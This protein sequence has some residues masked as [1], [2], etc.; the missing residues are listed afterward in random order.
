M[1]SSLHSHGATGAQRIEPATLPLMQYM[2]AGKPMPVRE[3]RL[4]RVLADDRLG[5][6]LR[7]MYGIEGWTV[8]PPHPFETSTPGLI[9]LHRAGESAQVAVDLSNWPAL[10]SAALDERRA[11]G[12]E[13]DL[14]AAV[15]SIL[16]Q[17]LRLALESIGLAGVALSASRTSRER[18]DAA[19]HAVFFRIGDR[20]MALGI[21]DIDDR[22][23]DHLEALVAE[24]CVPYPP[25]ISSLAV[26][27]RIELGVRTLNIAA[28]ESLRPG[29]IVLGAIRHA[30]DSVFGDTPKPLSA[31]ITWGNHGMRQ[32]SATVCVDHHNNTLT[33][34]GVPS[35]SRM[36]ENEPISSGEP[37]E[38]PV[39]IGELDL[40][41]KIEI[42]TVALPVAQLSAL[43][44]GYVLELPV[45]VREAQVRLVSY[46]QMI[47]LGELVAVGDHIGVRIVRMCNQSVP[48]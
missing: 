3:A 29:D 23:I 4:A 28:L 35:M 16:L 17:P 31:P 45:P 41:V 30:P 9:E 42:D 44:A 20:E 21:V 47:A 43:R 5:A 14:H 12:P 1:E 22:W 27:G 36:T 8:L 40:P 34:T 46:G 15:A 18:L 32:L 2:N 33:L 13:A 6:L 7:V 48:V 26:P 11:P 25:R 37:G 10:A 19:L 39:A 38:A 24:Q